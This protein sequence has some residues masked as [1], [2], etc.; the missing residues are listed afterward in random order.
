MS[1]KEEP[2]CDHETMKRPIIHPVWLSQAPR[3]RRFT[4]LLGF[5]ILLLP[6]LPALAQSRG[7]VAVNRASG[8]RVSLYAGSHALVIGVSDYE[9]WPD[10]PNAVGDAEEV[11]RV[12]AGSGFRVRTVRDPTYKELEQVLGDYEDM[13]GVNEDRLVVY[14]AGHGETEILAGN[15]DTLGYIVPRDAPLQTEDRRGFRNGAISMR[16]IEDFVR[17]IQFRH[18]LLVFDS[19]FAGTI[20]SLQRTAPARITEKTARPARQFV[21]AG[22][23][24]E[25]VPDRS[26][27][28]RAFIE[29]LHGEAD[30]FTDGYVT[31]T[32]LGLYLTEKV[33]E[34]SNRTQHPQF[35]KL[36][37][38][39]LN[40]GDFV[41]EVGSVELVDRPSSV[42]TPPPAAVQFGHLQV[43]V[44]APNSQVYVDNVLQ[45]AA[46]PLDPA[47]IAN[48]GIGS[49]QVRV[50]AAGYQ[51]Q[52]QTATMRSGA[53]T[54]LV[55]AL[56]P[57]AK[58]MPA[59]SNEALSAETNGAI[60][61]GEM[62]LVPA[63][64]FTM[65][66]HAGVG[67]DDEH[68]AHQVTLR[69]FR[70]DRTEVTNRA[71]AQ[72]IAQTGHRVPTHRYG[73]AEYT[74][75]GE[76]PPTEFLDHPVEGVSWSDAEAYCSWAGKRLPTEAEWE[77]AARGQDG[78][79]FPWGEELDRSR[80]NYG[81]DDGLNEFG[82]ASDGWK[83][84]APVGS[85]AA[86][87]SPYGAYDMAGNLSEW[88]A[89]WYHSRYYSVSP[90]S[91]PKGP[92]TD[93]SLRVLRGGGW[94]NYTPSLRTSARNYA[95]VNYRG[96]ITFRCAV[97]D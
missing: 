55:V 70:I 25:T 71:Y 5:G 42:I 4:V 22:A 13:V 54:Q 7:L 58:R 92:A 53:W 39:I 8:E 88:V 47:E 19:C 52:S 3:R 27:F 44:N 38:P 93:E 45:G 95:G 18:A 15:L 84:T 51:E 69:G 36:T 49:F 43:N 50:T 86:G 6:I 17:R 83:S 97:D 31:G 89:D 1:S 72:F 64:P 65:G 46:S 77:K 94:R 48:L 57:V 62:V 82:D 16:R 61:S 56:V 35:G 66:S 74:W 10:L 11:A 20:F 12:F 91:N 28:K 85:Y 9:N 37:D 67:E 29:A 59:Q 30:L 33:V 2:S 76:Q 21:T 26:V 23:A 79:T 96:T 80:A 87:V 90:D 32:E 73:V 41:F 40:K 78:R 60:R 68:P 63:G 24:G 14:F 75:I 81:A 34:Y